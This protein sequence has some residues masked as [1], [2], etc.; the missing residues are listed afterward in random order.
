MKS[1]KALQQS[2]N[3]LVYFIEEA[4]LHWNASLRYKV[5]HPVSMSL[6]G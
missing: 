5:I 1:M 3:E 4:T 6:F 2:K